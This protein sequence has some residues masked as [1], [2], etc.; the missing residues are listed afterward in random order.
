[1]G[2]V[3]PAVSVTLFAAAVIAGVAYFFWTGPGSGPA[4]VETAKAATKPGGK[5]DGKGRGAAAAPVTAAT[6]TEAT[7][8]SSSPR[9]ARSSRWPT[10]AV[11]PRV[12]GQI[13]EVAFR[14]GD[15]VTEGSVLFRLDDRMVRAQIAQ[16]EAGIAKDE[17]GL[18]RRPGR[19]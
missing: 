1:M 3:A 13:V 19:R 15:L 7:C 10:V 8:R 17:A 14:E 12:D 2:F 5:A 16:A 6:V 11:R 9:P 18:A 4:P